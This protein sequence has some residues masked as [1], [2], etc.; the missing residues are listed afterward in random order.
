M[1]LN[2]IERQ[3]RRDFITSPTF[4]KVKYVGILSKKHRYTEG[5]F[6]F[7]FKIYKR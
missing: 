2:D 4:Y 5:S 7:K 1:F 6:F 3:R